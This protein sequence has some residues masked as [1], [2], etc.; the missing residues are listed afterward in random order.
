MATNPAHSRQIPEARPLPTTRLET[1]APTAILDDTAPDVAAKSPVQHAVE[2]ITPIGA[3]LAVVSL[4]EIL[5]GPIRQEIP[6]AIPAAVLI[7]LRVWL[8]YKA[9]RYAARWVSK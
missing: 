8:A 7:V 2:I 5:A 3:F 1:S 4:T 9:A 6:G